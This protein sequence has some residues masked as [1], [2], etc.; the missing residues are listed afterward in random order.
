MKAWIWSLGSP[1]IHTNAVD[2]FIRLVP[3]IEA[4]TCNVRT[5]KLLHWLSNHKLGIG[6]D[7]ILWILLAVIVR[8]IEREFYHLVES[9]LA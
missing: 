8:L 6:K 2:I 7:I 1:I 4:Y 5:C 9:T 3:S